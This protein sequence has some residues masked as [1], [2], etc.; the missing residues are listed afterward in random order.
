MPVPILTTAV[1][2]RIERSILLARLRLQGAD[3]A[4][5]GR[6][7][8]TRSADAPWRNGVFRFG[9]ADVG[10][11]ADI[12]D[13]FP[14]SGGPTFHLMPMDY[15]AAVGQALAG[16]GF[17]PVAFRQA[18]LYGVPVPTPACPAGLSIERVSPGSLDD[19][20]GIV[21]DAFGYRPEWRAG[22]EAD[23]RRQSTKPDVHL[24][25]ARV[26]GEPAGAG[27]LHVGR[28][29]V[30]S[31]GWAAVSPGHRRRGC[32]AAL[33]AHRS[34]AAHARG[35]RLVVGGADFGS[36]SFRNQQRAGLRL[37]YVESTWRAG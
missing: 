12:L 19:V 14:P 34:A 30:A 10:R 5:H 21:V 16:I 4:R 6:T 22:A 23:L 31:L 13:C 37:A 29:G 17:R 3:V 1:A 32:H 36:A 15:T 27:A 25:L 7:V 28:N 26:A 20:V 9:P 8:A 35:A 11:L 24:Y 33:I 2:R 18:V